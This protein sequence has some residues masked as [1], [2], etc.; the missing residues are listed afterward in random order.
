[1]IEGRL[2][3]LYFAPALFYLLGDDASEQLEVVMY[4]TK[5]IRMLAGDSVHPVPKVNET[6]YKTFVENQ[7]C[8]LVD[9]FQEDI[10]TSRLM[11]EQ[12]LKKMCELYTNR[13]ASYKA[14][15]GGHIPDDVERT[16]VHMDAFS[17][18]PFENAVRYITR[19]RIRNKKM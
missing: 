11:Y 19:V 6:S 2:F 14:H 15:T 8:S 5:S 10:D 3:L 18:Y 17:A 9:Y 12:F 16:G 4:L 13:A 1:M 7:S